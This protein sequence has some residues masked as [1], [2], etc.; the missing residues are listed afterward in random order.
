MIQFDMIELIV[1]IK[2]LNKKNIFK[3]YINKLRQ[4]QK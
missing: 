4:K 3:D 2:K 1:V